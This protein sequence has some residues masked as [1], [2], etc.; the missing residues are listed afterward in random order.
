KA[1]LLELEARYRRVALVAP[2]VTP[3]YVEQVIQFRDSAA[4]CA[5]GESLAVCHNTALAERLYRELLPLHDR[6]AHWGLLGVRWVGPVA[7]SLAQLAAALGDPQAADEHF[8]EA[9]Q[10]ATRMRA[11]PWVARICCEWAELL[12]A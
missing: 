11:R 7:R 1:Y 4:M 8:A 12:R 10:V 2:V 9:L 6:C 5:L 3:E